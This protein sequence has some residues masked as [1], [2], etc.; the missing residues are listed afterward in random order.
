MAPVS[1]KN[2]DRKITARLPRRCPRQVERRII[3]DYSDF[4]GSSAFTA[5]GQRA[6]RAALVN[7]H[8]S[9]PRLLVDAPQISTGGGEAKRHQSLQ[10][11]VP[12]CV[13][14]GLKR[15]AE[16]K[17]GRRLKTGI[18]VVAFLEPII[19]DP[20]VYMVHVVKADIAGKPLERPRQAK[21]GGAP[22]RG[23]GK[24]PACVRHPLR[25]LEEVLDREQP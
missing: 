9:I 14:P 11:A 25:V 8:A 18:G 16:R 1:K 3:A 22:E 2:L 15:R 10:I 4:T 24:T 13:A 19:W 12:Q 7:G 17:R 23:R 6:T 20:R 5:T 21:I